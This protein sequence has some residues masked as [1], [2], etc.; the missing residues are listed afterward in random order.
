MNGSPDMAMNVG[1]SNSA[2]SSRALKVLVVGSA[3]LDMLARPLIDSPHRDRIGTVSVEVGGTACNLAFNLRRLEQRV[4]LLTAWGS[5]PVERMMAGHIESQGVELMADEVRGMPLAAFAAQLTANG[6]LESAISATPVD[7]HIFCEARIN[8]ALDGVDYAIVEANLSEK[9]VSAIA[10]RSHELGIPVFALAVSEDK[11]ERLLPALSQSFFRAVFMNAEECERLLA[12]EH[13]ADPA[14][15]AESS[16]TTLVVT[17]GERGAMAYLPDGRRLRLPPPVLQDMK[18]LLGV[19]DAFSVGIIDGMMRGRLTLEQASGHAHG[20]VSEIA[21]QEAC[22]VFSLNALNSMVNVLYEDARNDRLTGLLRRAAFE[23]EYARFQHSR[24]NTVLVI[25]CDR[26]KQVND[27]LGHDAGDT[28]LRGVAGAIKGSIRGWDLPCRWGGDEFVVLL[29]RT[30]AL[31]GRGVAERIR[32]AAEGMPLHGVT[33]SM[34]VT[35]GA[36]GEALATVVARADAAMYA[37][38]RS[39]RNAVVMATA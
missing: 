19:G 1:E 10:Q 29:P 26:F 37:A 36:Q 8:E 23:N 39:G 34:G 4:R 32:V 7:T 12:I 28:V 25:D 2:A 3:H 30:K 15:I 9:T 11:A 24:D 6:N 21:Q 22:N 35:T 20:L 38:K 18:T 17:R 33:L 16:D 31:D 27:T 13:A 14:E 5:S